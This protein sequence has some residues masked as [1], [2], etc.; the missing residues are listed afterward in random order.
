MPSF[1]TKTLFLKSFIQDFELLCTDG[2]RASFDSAATCNWGKVKSHVIM[3]AAAR[4]PQTR[5]EYKNLFKQVN[6][7]LN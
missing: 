1:E 2:R 7:A 5:T 3:T 4:D 6:L